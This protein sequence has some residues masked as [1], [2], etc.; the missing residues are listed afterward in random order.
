MDGKSQDII[1]TIITKYRYSI[2]KNDKIM[3]IF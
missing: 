3:I 1:F 2:V